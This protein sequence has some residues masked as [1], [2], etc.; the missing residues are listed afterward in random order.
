MVKANYL[1]STAVVV[2]TA[3]FDVPQGSHIGPNSLVLLLYL[4]LFNVTKISFYA[5]ATTMLG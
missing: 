2:V 5:T 4:Y 1:F 3:V